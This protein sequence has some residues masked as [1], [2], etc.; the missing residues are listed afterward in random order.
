MS[1]TFPHNTLITDSGPTA[2]LCNSEH[3]VY[4]HVLVTGVSGKSLYFQDHET[5]I[6]TTLH[7]AAELFTGYTKLISVQMNGQSLIV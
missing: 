7:Q 5:K 6:S 2:S 1:K 4:F 3:S